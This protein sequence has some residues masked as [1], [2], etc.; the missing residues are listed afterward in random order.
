M[1]E[2]SVLRYQVVNH[3]LPTTSEAFVQSP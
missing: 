3:E 1:N 2:L